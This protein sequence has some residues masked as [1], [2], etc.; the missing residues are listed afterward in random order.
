LIKGGGGVY[1]SVQS[2]IGEI[3]E[4]E[5]GRR[6]LEHYLPK[7]VRSPSFQMTYGM[8][9]HGVCKFRRWKLK[10]SVYAEAAAA[11]EEIEI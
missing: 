5:Q 4:T 9:F 2:K 7:L 8:S 1:L 6:L 3:Y 11:L 10:R